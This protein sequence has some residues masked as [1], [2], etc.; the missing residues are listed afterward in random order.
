MK[1]LGLVL[2]VLGV[3]G[4]VYQGFTVW[5]RKKVV[6]AGPLQVDA[7]TPTTVWVPPAL[8]LGAVVLGVVALL[9][10]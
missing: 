6:D 4:L 1:I 7:A 3:L 5:T 2:I 8:A 9:L 10:G